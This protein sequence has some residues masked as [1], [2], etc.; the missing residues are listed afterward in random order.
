MSSFVKI[1]SLIL[2]WF[3]YSYSNFTTFI[4]FF[5][6][7]LKMFLKRNWNTFGF[8]VLPKYEIWNNSHVL[9]FLRQFFY[10]SALKFKNNWELHESEKVLSDLSSSFLPG[11]ALWNA[12]S[13]NLVFLFH[14]SEEIIL[15]ERWKAGLERLTRHHSPRLLA[16]Y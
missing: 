7:N 2:K 13:K 1:R 5:V 6:T 10:K 8:F 15:T 14:P 12:H 16:V 4:Q 9:K 11:H 3:F